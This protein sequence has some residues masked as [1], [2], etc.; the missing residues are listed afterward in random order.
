[1]NTVSSAQR[2]FTL[3]EKFSPGHMQTSLRKGIFKLPLNFQRRSLT[4]FTLIE[5]LVVMFIFTI[6]TGVILANHARFNSS[7]L[8]GSLA[9]NVALS[10]REAQVYGL[11]V[12]PFG[13]NF[14]VGYGVHFSAPDRYVFFADTNVSKRYEAGTDSIVQTYTVGQGHT[15]KRFCGTLSDGSSQCSDSPSNPIHSL[16]VVFF[17]PDPDANISSENPGFYSGALVTVASPSGETR[18][19]TVQST[20]QISVTN[21]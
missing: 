13:A 14:E 7:V 12:Q 21:P 19:I 2:A 4:G 5:M 11:S 16:D 17:R 18:T 1:M 20:G 3:L 15:V 6:I 9:Y 10:I 8:L